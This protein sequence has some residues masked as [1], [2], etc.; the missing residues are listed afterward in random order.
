VR[1]VVRWHA[2]GQTPKATF[3]FNAL[4]VWPHTPRQA[5]TLQ[6]FHGPSLEVIESVE[7]VGPEGMRVRLKSPLTS[8]DLMPKPP[9]RWAT[10]PLVVDGIFQ[11]LILWCRSQRGVPSLP[12]RVGSWKQ[13]A[14]FSEGHVNAAI[15]IREVDGATVTSDVEI[16]NEAGALVAKLDGCVCTMSATLD[17]AFQPETISAAPLTT[18]A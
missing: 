6:L 9:T 14:P 7:G 4:E 10:N 18:N 16:T 15:S 12:S 2:P 8:V 13:F 17:Q 3:E 11:A 1:A 5:Y